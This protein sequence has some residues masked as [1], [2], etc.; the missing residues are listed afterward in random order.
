M[1][2]LEGAPELLDLILS[3]IQLYDLLPVR[4]ACRVLHGRIQLRFIPVVKEPHSLIP[5]RTT[6]DMTDLESIS[7][8]EVRHQIEGFA[9]YLRWLRRWWRIWD[10]AHPGGRE[11]D[12]AKLL[13]LCSKRTTLDGYFSLAPWWRAYGEI[14]S[15]PWTPEQWLENALWTDGSAVHFYQ[16]RE[17]DDDDSFRIFYT[18]PAEAWPFRRRRDAAPIT[19]RIVLAP[20]DVVSTKKADER[21]P[22]LS[23]SMTAALQTVHELITCLLPGCDVSIAPKR[24]WR[25]TNSKLTRTDVQGARRDGKPVRQLSS[26]ALQTARRPIDEA[27]ETELRDAG[28]PRSEAD[29][30]FITFVVAPHLWPGGDSQGLAWVYSTPI[31]EINE[32]TDQRIDAW[33]VST[34]QIESFVETPT[35]QLK[36]LCKM[37]LY[38]VLLEALDLDV[39][40]NLDCVMNNC[41][42]VGESEKVPIRLCP[43]CMRKLHLMGVVADVPACHARVASFLADKG[44]V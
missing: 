25:V 43:T 35:E 40:E 21:M 39:C 6:F 5:D 44:L 42:S 30:P 9:R 27:V 19:R 13:E 26:D 16:A 29:E 24:E 36:Q 4:L 34:H 31:D 33:V 18:T 28:R 41:D 14:V 22:L 23:Q 15:S 12:E 2:A 8:V 1:N 17:R 11:R 7:N 37:L 3:A 32:M 38:C 10:Q 20:L